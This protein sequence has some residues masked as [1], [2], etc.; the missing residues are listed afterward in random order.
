MPALRR[1]RSHDPHRETW[2]VSYGDVV[3]GHIGLP[4]GCSKTA[5]SWGFDPIMAT[6][7]RS[8]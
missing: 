6:N 8:R 3:V 1:R 4:G 5:P 2:N 7:F